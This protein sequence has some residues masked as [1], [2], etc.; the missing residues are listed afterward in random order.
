MKVRYKNSGTEAD[1]SRFNTHGVGEVLTGDDSVLISEL[2]AFLTATQE[3]K[4]MQQAFK[5]RDLISDNYNTCFFEPKT[6]EDRI[7]GYTL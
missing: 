6:A 4:D 2:D 3:W 5:N 1:A 7:R